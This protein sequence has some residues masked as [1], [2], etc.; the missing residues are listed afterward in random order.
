MHYDRFIIYPAAFIQVIHMAGVH[1]E[2]LHVSV[3]F[4]ASQAG[5]ESLLQD[6]PVIILPGENGGHPGHAAV[7]FGAFFQHIHVQLSSNAGSMGILERDDMFYA[8]R[9][10]KI[11][12]PGCGHAVPDMPRVFVEPFPYRRENTA[13][14]NMYMSINYGRKSGWN[15]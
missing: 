14:E 11:E 10:Q 1:V 3:Q 2:A 13:G 6:F 9:Q 8:A 7:V 4:Q 5:I 12:Y 15:I